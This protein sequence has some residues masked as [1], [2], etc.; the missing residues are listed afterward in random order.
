MDEEEVA[1]MTAEDNVDE[2]LAQFDLAVDDFLK[3]NP[4]PV[5]KVY[6]HRQDATLANPLGPAVRGW[7]QVAA[8]IE[9]AAS[10]A[11]EGEIGDVENVVK[12]VTPQL[13]YIVRMERSEVK[14]GGQEAVTPISLRV[15][16]IMRPEDGVWKIVHRHADPITTA[17]PAES[18]IQQV[19]PS[20]K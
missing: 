4:E 7:E 18:V 9:L 2:L 12:Y 8:T 5:K 11:R 19:A 6:S 3:G 14:V 20:R 15:T 16:M 1:W 10:Q 17:R 13:A